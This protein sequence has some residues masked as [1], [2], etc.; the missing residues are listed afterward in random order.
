MCLCSL[1]IP[2]LAEELGSITIE[3]QDSID[4]LSKDKVSFGYVQIASLEKGRYVINEDYEELDVDFNVELNGDEFAKVLE[5]LDQLK[6]KSENKI[7]TNS[8]G[9]AQV[10]DLELGIY[11]V[12]PIDVHEY[13]IVSSTLVSIPEWNEEELTYDVHVLPKHIPFPKFEIQKRDSYSKEIIDSSVEFTL[14]KDSGCKEIIKSLKGQGSVSVLCNMDSFYIKETKAPNGYKLSNQM[15]KVEVKNHTL[16]VNGEQVDSGYV[17]N[18]ENTKN[19]VK[20]SVFTNVSLYVGL[21][22]ASILIFICL[23]RKIYIQ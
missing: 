5:R 18:F 15:I 19:N 6:I 21:S 23:K 16:Y 17:F 10:N 2:I 14:Y 11:Y 8:Q 3:L 9:I 4:D 1:C 20:T 7:E 12:Y 13:E 22:I